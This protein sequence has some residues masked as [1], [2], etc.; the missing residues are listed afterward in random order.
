MILSLHPTFFLLHLFP[1]SSLQ[2]VT[3]GNAF[4]NIAPGVECN[5]TDAV[6][7]IGGGTVNNC[8]G[9]LGS[10]VAYLAV[11]MLFNVR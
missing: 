7:T 6:P 10:L 2:G 1:H 4:G 9:A 8:D 5:R 3:L 11:M